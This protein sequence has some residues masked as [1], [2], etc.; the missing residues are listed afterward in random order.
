MYLVNYVEFIEFLNSEKIV[1]EQT[2]ITTTPC[3][4]QFKRGEVLKAK[5]EVVNKSIFKWNERFGLTNFKD[6][7][8]KYWI[9]GKEWIN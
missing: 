4:V 7:Q 9:R 3:I 8:N 1:S 2:I 5:V 6:S